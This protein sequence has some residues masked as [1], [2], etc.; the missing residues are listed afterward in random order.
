MTSTPRRDARRS[1][2]RAAAAA[3]AALPAALAAPAARAQ[4]A[5]PAAPI[6]FI[7]PFPAGSGT[8]VAARLLGERL[9]SVLG[10]PVIVDSH[11]RSTR[12]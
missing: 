5:W 6:R 8:D 11:R 3:A 10:Q 9:S 7:V 1:L 4:A 2:L 12:R